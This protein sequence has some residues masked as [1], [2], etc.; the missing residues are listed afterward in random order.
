LKD[1]AL[2]KD[3]GAVIVFTDKAETAR[4]W[5]EQLQPLLGD[6]PLLIV[7][8][9]QASPLIHPYYQSGQ[10]DGLVSGMAG[11]LIYESILG[12]EGDAGRNYT[13]LQLLSVLM[14][15]LIVIG[16]FITLVKPKLNRGVRK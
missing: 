12:A 16:G 9:A 14:A 3:F 11:G 7:A 1:V 5:V 10:V 2:M 13:S 15:G 6:T 8:S 4:V